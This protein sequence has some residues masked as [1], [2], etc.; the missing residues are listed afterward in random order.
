MMIPSLCWLAIPEPG[1]EMPPPLLQYKVLIHIDA[2]TD[3]RDAGE[4]WFLGGSSDSGQSGLP[5]T[6]DEFSDGGQG[7]RPR[8]LVW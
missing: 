1:S 3:F 2:M 8:Q 6:P 4:P 5:G 7:S